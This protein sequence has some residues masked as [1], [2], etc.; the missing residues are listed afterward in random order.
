M[1]I[2]KANVTCDCPSK[3]LPE[4]TGG[5]ATN[6]APHSYDWNDDDLRERGLYLDIHPWQNVVFSLVASTRDKEFQRILHS[7]INIAATVRNAACFAEFQGF[8]PI[9]ANVTLRDTSRRGL[10]RSF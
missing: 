9:L 7:C 4:S 8:S 5:C 6:S 1:L 10:K 3:T 2:I